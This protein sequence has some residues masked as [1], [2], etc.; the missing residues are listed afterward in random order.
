MG[1]IVKGVE[2]GKKWTGYALGKNHARS[3]GATFAP[4]TLLELRIG[5]PTGKKWRLN[6]FSIR[7]SLSN[8]RSRPFQTLSRPFVFQ[9]CPQNLMDRDDPRYVEYLEE[10]VQALQRKV[11]TL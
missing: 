2:Q 3:D 8:R 5:M 10:R 6:R 11:V 7:P 9:R 1:G 4:D